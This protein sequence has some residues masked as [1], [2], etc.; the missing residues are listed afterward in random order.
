M[1]FLN[2]FKKDGGQPERTERPATPAPAEKPRP[3]PRPATKTITK[4]QL[5]TVDGKERPAPL[6]YQRRSPTHIYYTQKAVD[7]WGI[8]DLFDYWLDLNH[9]LHGELSKVKTTA[10]YQRPQMDLE[11]ERLWD[12][13]AKRDHRPADVALLLRW[14]FTRGLIDMGFERHGM[15]WYEG[16]IPQFE[17]VTERREGLP[18]RAFRVPTD[19]CNEGVI[20]WELKNLNYNM[21]ALARTFGFPVIVA[22][23]RQINPRFDAAQIREACRYV[24]REE[25]HL[26]EI[27]LMRKV[28]G[29]IV[30]NCPTDAFFLTR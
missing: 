6:S 12:L 25:S 18:V 16:L 26:R 1:G 11:F 15:L 20:A 29:E 27:A 3:A 19:E 14:S 4:P 22:T 8:V 21:E 17:S 10:R 23:L 9:N 5:V 7:E 28:H 13:L 24:S 30:P 2:F